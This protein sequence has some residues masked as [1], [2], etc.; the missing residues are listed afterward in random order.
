MTTPLLPLPDGPAGLLLSRDLIFTSKVTGTARALG[1]RVLVA[2]NSALAEA[3]IGQWRP[4]VVF[5]DLAAGDLVAAPALMA[6]R[7]AAG[8]GLIVR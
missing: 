7:L 4:K 6:Y 1:S 2:G 3:M 5:V 8:P